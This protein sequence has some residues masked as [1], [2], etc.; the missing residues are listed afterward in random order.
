M[1]EGID[2]LRQSVAD[3]VRN[4]FGKIAEADVGRCRA[5]PVRKLIEGGDGG[6]SVD[7]TI[8]IY[9]QTREGELFNNVDHLQC[10]AISGGVEREVHR[11]NHVRFAT[12]TSPRPV[13]RCRCGT[14][15]PS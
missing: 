9:R 2:E 3:V 11:P 10:A 12:G 13:G 4:E 14:R 6:I 8:D 5:K 1:T 7:R 15:R